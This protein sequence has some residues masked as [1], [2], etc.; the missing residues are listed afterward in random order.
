MRVY[1]RRRRLGER[2]DPAV[3]ERVGLSVA[4][5]EEMHRYLAIANYE[6]RFVIPTAHREEAED[7]YAL[8]GGCG[9]SFGNGCHGE[10]TGG[11]LF[12]GPMGRRRTI[13][14]RLVKD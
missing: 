2:D 3:L 9:F 13:P 10:E 4:E 5:A 11:S 1:Y 8:R 14:I 7:A 6:D 12:G